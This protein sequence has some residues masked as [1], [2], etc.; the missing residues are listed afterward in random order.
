M[1]FTAQR[2]EVLEGVAWQ[3]FYKGFCGSICFFCG[4]GYDQARSGRILEV[5]QELKATFTGNLAQA[6][7][8]ES[9]AQ[10]DYE[11][12]SRAKANQKGRTSDSLNKM[13]VS[14]AEQNREVSKR[15]TH[16]SQQSITSQMFRRTMKSFARLRAFA[17]A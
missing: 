4:C 1:L 6:E 15:S 11:S 16:Y 17:S 7:S 10:S 8:T 12:L 14:R 13:E 5:L 9:K 3:R 2:F